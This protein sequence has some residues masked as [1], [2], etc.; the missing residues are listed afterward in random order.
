[1][2]RTAY[3]LKELYALPLYTIYRIHSDL[4]KL[5]T[6]SDLRFIANVSAAVWGNEDYVSALRS[7]DVS[8]YAEIAEHEAGMTPEERRQ[9]RVWQE[10]KGLS[11]QTVSKQ[12]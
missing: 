9:F 10:L 11:C 5:D 8:F 12:T 4:E 6:A 7:V 2:S 3:K 1:M